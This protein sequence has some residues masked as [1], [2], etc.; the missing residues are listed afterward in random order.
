M[1]SEL[2]RYEKLLAQKKRQ[3]EDNIR[4]G[5]EIKHEINELKLTISRLDKG[6]QSVLP[7]G[8]KIVFKDEDDKII[9]TVII[10]DYKERQTLILLNDYWSSEELHKWYKFNYEC[11][12]SDTLIKE[13]CNDFNVELVSIDKEFE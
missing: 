9:E 10:E 3:Y 12:Y 6:M 5:I 8:T 1:M 11:M 2:E 7:I 13:F 4:D